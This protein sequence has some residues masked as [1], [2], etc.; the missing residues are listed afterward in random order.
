MSR[1]KLPRSL[2]K[3]IREEKARIRRTVKDPAEVARRI[4]AL[5]EKYHHAA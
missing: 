3:Y 2:R 5:V 4:Q 1:P